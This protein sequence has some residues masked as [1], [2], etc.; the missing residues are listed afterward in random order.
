MGTRQC[1][2]AVFELFFVDELVGFAEVLAALGVAEDDIVA[3]MAFARGFA[4]TI[5]ITDSGG[6]LQVLERADNVPFLTVAV[7]TDKAWTAASFG[8][9]TS[10]W[11]QYMA[12]PT[13]APLAHHPRLT[14]VGGGVPIII[15]GQIAG[16]IGISGGSSVQDHEAAEEA[17][18][19]DEFNGV[20]VFRESFCM[21]HLALGGTQ[22]RN[23]PSIMAVPKLCGVT[24]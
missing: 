20:N 18:S 21:L 19:S 15:D 8:M 17:P 1:W 6:H 12:E 7:A 13:V 9:S 23:A 3:P 11:N 16:G 5:A 24:H 10:Q 2:R 22:G 4:A 14:P